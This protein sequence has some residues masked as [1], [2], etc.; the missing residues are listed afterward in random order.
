[1]TEV[2]IKASYG[3]MLAERQ[4]INIDFGNDQTLNIKVTEEQ[5]KNLAYNITDV[6]RTSATYRRKYSM[7][8]NKSIKSALTDN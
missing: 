8:L 2:K 4:W 7:D 6:I 3:G 1:M 5:L